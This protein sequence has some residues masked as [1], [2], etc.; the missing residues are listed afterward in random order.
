MASCHLVIHTAIAQKT[1]NDQSEFSEQL[2]NYI[3][4]KAK[5]Q[6]SWSNIIQTYGP[7]MLTVLVR[8]SKQQCESLDLNNLFSSQP[9][10]E[11]SDED[12]I[13]FKQGFQDS[14]AFTWQYIPEDMITT[15]TLANDN[16]AVSTAILERIKNDTKPHGLCINVQAILA[17]AI[18]ESEV[19][20]ENLSPFYNGIE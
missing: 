8:G 14:K 12:E 5:L 19:S 11:N 7:S 9:N 20:N 2:V 4:A 17:G 13:I 10:E 18:K 15:R 6:L 3:H 1:E 16:F